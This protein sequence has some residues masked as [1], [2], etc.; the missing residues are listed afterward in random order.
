MFTYSFHLLLLYQWLVS[1]LSIQIYLHG[2]NYL[3]LNLT[4]YM[5]LILLI[6]Q[7]HV[8]FHL[9]VENTEENAVCF[10]LRLPYFL[11]H[12]LH[13]VKFHGCGLNHKSSTHDITLG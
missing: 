11:K 2:R 13:V 8:H 1:G 7:I 10:R 3:T 12:V 6:P 5:E 9:H 4:I